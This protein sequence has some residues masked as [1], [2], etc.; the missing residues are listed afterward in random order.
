MRVP[1][2]HVSSSRN[3]RPSAARTPSVLKKFPVTLDPVSSYGSP[4]PMSV[5]FPV[6]LT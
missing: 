2:D 4:W 1:L 5:D 3:V 6:P